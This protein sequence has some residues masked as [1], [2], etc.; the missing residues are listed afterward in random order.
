MTASSTTGKEIWFE[1]KI[2]FGSMLKNKIMVVSNGASTSNKEKEREISSTSISKD[3][4]LSEVFEKSKAEYIAEILLGVIVEGLL[5]KLRSI[6]IEQH[7]SFELGFKEGL[8]DLFSGLTDIFS[9]LAK[10]QLVL[11]GVEKRQ[12]SDEFLRSWL[13]ELRRVAYDIDDVLDEFG[14]NILQQKVLNYSSPSNGIINM[15]NEIKIIYKSLNSLKGDIASYEFRAEFENSIPEISFNVEIDSFLDDSKVNQNVGN[16]TIKATY[17]DRVL[18]ITKTSTRYEL[19]EYDFEQLIHLRLLHIF[20][21]IE[22][23]PKSITKL[24][25]LQTL[26]IEKFSNVGKLPED[27]SNL[28][29]LRHISIYIFPG[30]RIG[31]NNCLLKNMGRLTSLQTLKFFSL[32]QDEGYRIKEI[33]PL[34]NLREIDI[35][36]LEKVTNE[37]EA[38]SAQL[39]EKEIFNLGLFWSIFDRELDNYDND[40]KVL[41]G[42]H[43]HPNLKSLKIEGY[44]GKKFPSWVND[45]SLFHNLIHIELNSCMRC[46]EVPNLGHLPRLRVLDIEGLAMVRSIG[47]EFYSYRDGSFRNTTTLFPSLRMLKLEWMYGLEDWKDAKELTSAGEVLLV[48]PCLE[49]LIIIRCNRL[50]GLP[51]LL[52]TCI[53]LQKLVV[54]DCP[55]LRSLPGVPSV[56]QHLEIIGCGIDELPSGLHLCTSLHLK[57]ESCPNLKSIPE[58]LHTCVS[59]QK[60]VIQD[61]TRLSSLRGVPSVIQHLEIIGCGID[62]LPSG[63]HLC[64]SLQYL[65]IKDCPN[66]KSIPESLHTCVSLQKFVIQDCTHLSSLRGVPSVIQH[67][68]IIGCG[69]DE[70]PSGLHL[71]TSLQYLKIKGCRNLKSIPESLH[72]CVSLQKFVIQDCTHLS[73]LR[74]VPS[75]IQRLEIIGCGID[76]LPSGLHLCTSLQYLGIK[77]CLNLKSIPDLGEVFHSLIHLK[78]SNCPDLRLK[79][80]REGRLKALE[81]GGFIEE[82]DAFPILCYP[83]INTR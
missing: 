41:E 35:Y 42:L 59:L 37:E 12:A 18:E 30:P 40:E 60:F 17:F 25:N 27:L 1:R 10:I 79:L 58:S 76:E 65:G 77:D 53:S 24:Y 3:D 45:F 47:S 81:I 8:T 51:D 61:F 2:D 28:I 7:I 4:M 31:S 67:L 43:P 36:N 62:E 39:K 82:L 23:L 22:E 69:I 48:F 83:S 64:T 49:E 13:E 52:H 14:Y 80:L 50:R 46:E 38:K 32:G 63:L 73:S 57:I 9:L 66:L 68:E 56:I 70:L 21:G 19:T 55:E 5:A 11:N 75:V 15:A 71:C 74:G 78:I 33:G 6:F 44:E 16:N 29:N 72:T 54:K 34:K 20:N 26:R